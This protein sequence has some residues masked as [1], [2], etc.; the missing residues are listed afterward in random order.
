MRYSWSQ[1]VGAKPRAT[2][3]PGPMVTATV[4]IPVP[5]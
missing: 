4:R 5:Q 3:T 2:P 1:S